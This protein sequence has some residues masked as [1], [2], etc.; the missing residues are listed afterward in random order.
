M[1][2]LAGN[3]LSKD[4]EYNAYVIAHLSFSD[5]QSGGHL[6]Y[7]DY[8]LVESNSI[9]AAREQF[10]DRI[11]ELGDE[12][13]EEAEA[14]KKQQEREESI[15]EMRRLGLDEMQ[16]LMATLF[17]QD[18]EK[19]HLGLLPFWG[20][21]V[22]ELKMEY[23]AL[24]EPLIQSRKPLVQ[25]K[26]EERALFERTMAARRSQSIEKSMQLIARF[27][28]RLKRLTA[29]VEREELDGAEALADIARAREELDECRAQLCELQLQQQE[30]EE[31]LTST[32]GSRYSEFVSA[33][34]SDTSA[35]FERLRDR[36]Q[37]KYNDAVAR[38]MALVDEVS[39][40]ANADDD[41]ADGKG[42]G[43]TPLGGAGRRGG[44]AGGAFGGGDP[45]T[46]DQASFL[47]DKE[48][49]LNAVSA[50]RDALTAALDAKEGRLVAA[51]REEYQR[52]AAGAARE[53]AERDRQR[54]TEIVAAR[55][56]FERTLRALEAYYTG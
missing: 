23:A 43:S 24:L 3:P 25:K 30:V 35:L 10:Q 9:A 4:P 41:D 46:E 36:V 5:W 21:I 42:G 48:A 53:S 7:L 44:G 49:V 51:E 6:S 29:S 16:E 45:L 52:L 32:F 39:N 40:L 2:S 11:M 33:I 12:E 20:E 37:G 27:T 22:E 15:N 54:T 8:R 50:S 1:L 31:Q 34:T 28:K 47:K 17:D 18:A 56:D 38:A 19:E 26:A 55:R 13:K 14:Q